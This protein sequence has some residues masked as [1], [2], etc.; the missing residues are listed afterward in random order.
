[1]LQ[2]VAMD[3]GARCALVD[4]RSIDVPGTMA[5]IAYQLRRQHARLR[6]FERRHQRYEERRA[7]L[8]ADPPGLSGASLLLAKLAVRLG[9][10]VAKTAIPV[11]GLATDVI[12]I[13]ATVDQ[14]DHLHALLT[15]ALRSRDDARLVLAPTEEL[16][17]L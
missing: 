3:Q 4:D 2:R 6:T 7:E 5:A 8:L 15:R 1:Q 9:L 16:T 10:R 12:P 14:A 17:P 11:M 13:D